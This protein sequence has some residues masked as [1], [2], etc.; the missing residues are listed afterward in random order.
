MARNGGPAVAYLYAFENSRTE[1]VETGVDFVRN[2]FA[3]L[4]HEPINYTCH[5]FVDNNTI[6]WWFFHFRHLRNDSNQSTSCF[7]HPHSAE[8]W[9]IPS[10][11]HNSA[12]AVMLLVKLD[13]LF[14]RK[15]AYH[16]WI[17][18]E[19]GLSIRLQVI[20][21]QSQGTGWKIRWN[22]TNHCRHDSN[23]FLVVQFPERL[24]SWCLI[25]WL[26]LPSR[27]EAYQRDNSR[28]ESHDQHRPRVWMMFLLKSISTMY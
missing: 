20:T 14:E 12:F 16:I 11:Y 22:V 23:L 26:P 7:S 19:E 15:F 27:V 24:W 18:H 13:H 6:L 28:L 17:E 10:T 8:S 4:L 25:V 9:T 2:V 21:C 5:F 3:G 1:Y